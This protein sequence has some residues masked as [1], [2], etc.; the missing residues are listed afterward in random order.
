MRSY[1]ELLYRVEKEHK[2]CTAM[3]D[4]AQ[5]FD[6]SGEEHMANS[7]IATAIR[8]NKTTQK[9]MADFLNDGHLGGFHGLE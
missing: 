8:I 9:V 1:D 6:R 5:R 2:K 3:I 4:Q 7:A